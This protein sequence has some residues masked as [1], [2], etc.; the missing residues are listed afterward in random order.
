MPQLTFSR[1]FQLTKYWKIET[2][3]RTRAK[4]FYREFLENKTRQDIPKETLTTNSNLI[5]DISTHFLQ[6]L[7]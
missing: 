2:N 1:S 4:L 6:K 3:S 5:Q 7:A